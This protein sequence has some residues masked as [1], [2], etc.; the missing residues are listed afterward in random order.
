MGRNGRAGDERTVAALD[1]G[2]NSFH[3]VVAR[4]DGGRL[5]VVD[6]LRERVALAAGLDAS[7]RLTDAAAERALACLERF[8]QRLH[9]MPSQA[10][11]A[12]GTNTLRQIRGES[13]FLARAEKA[14]GHPIEV[15]GG[16]EEARLIYLGV[17]HDVAHDAERGRRLV[18]DIGGGSTE[19]VV[20][21]RLL[22]RTC[23]SLY[24]GCVSYGQRFFGDGRISRNRMAR[25]R[26]AA[27]REIEPIRR[28]YASLGWEHAIG[29][30]GTILAVEKVVVAAGWCP[31]G[32]SA[33]ALRKLRKTIQATPSASALELPGLTEDRRDVIAPGVAILC[34]IFDSLGI[35]ALDTSQHALREGLLYDLFGREDDADLRDETVRA[36]QRRYHVDRRQAARVESVALRLLARAAPA[37]RLDA[38]AHAQLLA[39]AARLHEIGLSVARSGYHKHG[40]YLVANSDMPGFSQEEQRA[41]AA[42]VR[43][44]RRRF[45]PGLFAEVPEAT[46]HDVR[47]LA[48]L[49]RI[50]RRLCRSRSPR[51]TEPT[52]IVVEGDSVD[53]AFPD[54]W[55]DAH[56][57]SRAD[58][59]EEAELL[60][61]AGFT[62]RFA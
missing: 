4:R 15:I 21:D 33:K 59:D 31:S 46:Q 3:M 58:L 22:V 53:L 27:R 25:A 1:L 40:A 30:S 13:S 7:G 56:P 32:V 29:A 2:S 57:L 26:I 34:A 16:K 19:L 47:R 8:G 62:L 38:P 11:R 12:V 39:W 5:H 48:V 14:L 23:D 55:L 10:V 45:E 36:F 37:W 6:K 44:H 52:R 43:T 50:A 35:D 51:P 61:G 28:R 60:R 54:G 9:D 41:L 18:V 42:L 49:L 17:A 24:M 20:G